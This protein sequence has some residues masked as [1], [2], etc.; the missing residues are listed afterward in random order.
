MIICKL[1]L[2]N[3][4][5]ADFGK[6]PR[7]KSGLQAVCKEC[8]KQRNSKWQKENR[9]KQNISQ[10]SWRKRNPDKL[11]EYSERYRHSKNIS[12]KKWHLNNKEKNRAYL[13]SRRARIK[14]SEFDFFTEDD[15]IGIY[16]DSCY[17]CNKKIDLTA[18]RRVGVSGWQKGLHVEHV[19]PICKGGGNTLE[20]TRPS[21]GLCNLKKGAS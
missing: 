2:A 10:E 1:C 18:P 21:H 3:K 20:N 19:V 14:G 15:L 8:K 13:R 9:V 11:A 16:G 12:N 17:I 4:E 7:V 5:F 6:E